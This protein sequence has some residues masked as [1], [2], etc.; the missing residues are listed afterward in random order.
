MAIRTVV[1]RDQE[2]FYQVCRPYPVLSTTMPEY[3]L[4]NAFATVWEGWTKAACAARPEQ[5][6][7]A[8]FRTR[9]T[10]EAYPPSFPGL[11]FLAVRPESG[12]RMGLGVGR[13]KFVSQDGNEDEDV[14]RGKKKKRK[15]NTRGARGMSV[16]MMQN[17]CW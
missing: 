12:G 14:E 8:P 3:P 10:V 16:R 17:I 15:T 4:G 6:A 5:H 1:L 2:R 11:L 9:G 7:R 13:R